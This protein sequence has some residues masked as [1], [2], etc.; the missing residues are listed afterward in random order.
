MPPE[1]QGGRSAPEGQGGGSPP[2]G[3]DDPRSPLGS[4]GA[5]PPSP[6]PRLRVFTAL[7]RNL[8]SGLELL[9]PR[10]RVA[11]DSFVR[12]FDQVLLLLILGLLVWAGLD[13]LHADPGAALQLDGLFGWAAYL[14]VALFAGALVA[15]A[16][17]AEADTRALLVPALS[18]APYLFLLLWLLSDLPFIHDRPVLAVLGAIAYLEV[19]G[20][21]TVRAAYAKARVRTVLLA[22]ALIV[23][24]P[25]V[26]DSFGLDTRLWLAD[27]TEQAQDDDTATTESL[28]YDQP[29]RIAAAVERVAPAVPGKTHLFFVGFAGVGEQAVF[30]R[31]ALYAEQ[32][33]ADKFGTA[34]RSVELINDVR[35][36]DTYPLASVSGLDQAVKL[37]ADRMDTDEDVL[38]LM[39][40]SHGSEDGLAVSNGSLPLAQLAPADLQEILDDSRI[41]WRI[42]I[43]SACYAGVFLDE[44]KSD[45][46]LIVTAADAEHSSFGCDD[47]RE[48]T[49]FGEAFLHDSLP[50]AP[51]IEAAFKHAADLIQQ[52]ETAEHQIHSNPQLFVGELMR[53][54]LT[55]LQPESA[56]A[57]PKPVPGS[58]TRTALSTIVSCPRFQKSPH[59]TRTPLLPCRLP[60]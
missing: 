9:I 54:K 25:F 37:I 48:L 40:T 1:G 24:V 36:R 28:L 23:A 31:E 45:T 43:V 52:R 22:A 19:V 6:S 15:R 34:D 17:G 5:P 39:L 26:L 42:L 59:P 20:I 51:S 38:V 10:L 53:R 30:K 3:P 58:G 7:R 29:A 4:G 60:L 57:T 27:E 14:M 49:W 41:K 11:P 21:R 55:D 50:A 8:V 13:R 2:A 56:P 35:D 18:V 32:V 12:S 44:L 16:Q 46:T 47:S 33:F